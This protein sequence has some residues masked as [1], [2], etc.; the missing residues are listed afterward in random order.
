MGGSSAEREVSLVTGAACA[1]GL[2]E[3]GY[4]V[5]EIDV[6]RD[7][8][9]LVAALSPAPEA[10]FNALHGRWGE[11]GCIQ[12]ILELLQIPYTHSGLLASALAM[13]KPVAK[14][15]FEV[16]GLKCPEGWVVDRNTLMAGDVL[17]RP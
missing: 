4:D 2:R 16:A 9:A 6:G 13:N 5:V 11:D 3:A 17:P 8:A 12:G 10:V 7:V 14:R 1:K 15:L